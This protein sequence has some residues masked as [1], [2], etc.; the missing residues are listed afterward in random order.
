MKI[1]T[2]SGDAGSTGLV[3]GTRV[4]KSD[5]RVESYG[6]TDELC[7]MIG[8]AVSFM[9][10][11]DP[12]RE[13]LLKVQQVVFDCGSDLAKLNDSQQ[14]Y[15]VTQAEID[16][17]EERI[18]EYWDKTPEITRFILP[19][20]TRVASTL[21]VARCIARRAERCVVALM[22]TEAEINPLVLSYLNRL[23]DYFFALARLINVLSSE[24][25]IFY[26]NSAEVFTNKKRKRDRHVS[27]HS[28]SKK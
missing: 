13:E 7:S 23:S 15:K 26:Q 3:G 20:G 22:D 1:Y 27:S 21:H 17:L 2:R 5:L 6:T 16:F 9:E 18:D 11:E 10:Q 12:F 14:P 25:E 19:G 24:E 28:K 8:L 4:R